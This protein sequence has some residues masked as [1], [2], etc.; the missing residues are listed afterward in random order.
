MELYR[1]PSA[2]DTSADTAAV[3]AVAAACEREMRFTWL[4]INPKP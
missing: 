3:A 1:R 4:G 2:A